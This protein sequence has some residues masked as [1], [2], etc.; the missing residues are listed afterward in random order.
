[1]DVQ[2]ISIFLEALISVLSEYGVENIKKTSIIKKEV[3]NVNMDITALIGLTGGINGNVAY[4]FGDVTGRKLISAKLGKEIKNI[5]SIERN[6][7]EEI[8][9]MITNRAGEMFSKAGKNFKIT[10][11]SLVF[12]KDMVFV[13]S[14]VD[15]VCVDINTS[16]GEIQV[17]IGLEM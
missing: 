10:P 16:F 14:S 6:A 4:S 1:M 13:I 11:A 12:G 2:N 17:N 15:T 9:A 5:D 3:M 8:V 7:L